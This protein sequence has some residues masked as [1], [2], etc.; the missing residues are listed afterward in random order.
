[1]NTYTINLSSNSTN[2]YEHREMLKMMD[3]SKL[4]VN[5]ENISETYLPI[6]LK[7]DWGDGNVESFDSNPISE[8]VNAFKRSDIY[9]IERLHEYYPSSSSL[10]KQLTAQFLIKFSSGDFFWSIQPIEIRNYDYYESI[11]DLEIAH[12]ETDENDSKRIYFKT[13]KDS[14]ILKF[15]N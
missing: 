10:Y 4:V 5:F 12:V 14:Y 13:E 2:F 1:M 6:Y 15:K 3:F 8:N 9:D 7:I 11:Q